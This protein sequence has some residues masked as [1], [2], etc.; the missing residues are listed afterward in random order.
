MP[1][2]ETQSDSIAAM[3]QRWRELAERLSD[4]ERAMKRTHPETISVS[5]WTR[6]RRNYLNDLA[7]RQ[8][9]AVATADF[10]ATLRRELDGYRSSQGHH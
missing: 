10:L 8:A 4:L 5:R 3:E 2:G 7:N 9:N 6:F 1:R